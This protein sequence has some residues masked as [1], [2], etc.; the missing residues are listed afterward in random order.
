MASPPFQQSAALTTA[1]DIIGAPAHAHFRA[2]SLSIPRMLPCTTSWTASHRLSFARR[3]S[4][5][6]HTD[7]RT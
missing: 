6:S 5:S 7:E 4:L 2:N 3:S 1:D